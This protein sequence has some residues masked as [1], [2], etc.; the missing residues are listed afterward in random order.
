[1]NT[2]SKKAIKNIIRLYEGRKAKLEEREMVKQMFRFNELSIAEQA[3]TRKLWDEYLAKVL[4]TTACKEFMKQREGFKRGDITLVK[5][6]AQE[7]RI[8]QENNDYELEKPLGINP[9]EFSLNND[10]QQY[11]FAIKKINQMKDELKKM[12]DEEMIVEEAFD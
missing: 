12:G 2:L 4:T 9:W 10:C 5:R 6:I 11:W 1:M 3:E 7:A 8:R